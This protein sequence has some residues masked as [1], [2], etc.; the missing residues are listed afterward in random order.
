MTKGLALSFFLIF[1][2]IALGVGIYLFE[3]WSILDEV[4]FREKTTQML[5][6]TLNTEALN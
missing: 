5:N 1:L 4:S 3:D 2:T 6:P